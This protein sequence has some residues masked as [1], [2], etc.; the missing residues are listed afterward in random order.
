MPIPPLTLIWYFYKIAQYVCHRLK[1]CCKEDT[2]S[3]QDRHNLNGIFSEFRLIVSLFDKCVI[4]WLQRWSRSILSLQSDVQLLNMLQL[5]IMQDVLSKTKRKSDRHK[6]RWTLNSHCRT[7]EFLIHYSRLFTHRILFI[8]MPFSCFF[9][10]TA[11][12]VFLSF[13]LTSYFNL[14]LR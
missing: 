5:M 6:W 1:R 13:L 12:K 2:T 14:F 11:Q 3:D 4:D 7:D 10:R 9:V 8:F